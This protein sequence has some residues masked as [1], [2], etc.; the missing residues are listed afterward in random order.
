MPRGQ[1]RVTAHIKR[2]SQDTPDVTT[3]VLSEKQLLEL[4]AL[5]SVALREKEPHGGGYNLAIW[6]GTKGKTV[7]CQAKPPCEGGSARITLVRRS[8]A[9]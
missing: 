6:K 5:A 1:D 9:K 8:G 7:N 3:L 4:V 2:V